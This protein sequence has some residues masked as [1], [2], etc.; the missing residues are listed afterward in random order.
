MPIIVEVIFA[1]LTF[2]LNAFLGLF[3]YLRNNKSWTNRFFLAL[4]LFLNGYVILNFISLH[5]P[6]T[7]PATQLFWIRLVMSEASFLGPTLF[8]LVHTFPKDKIQLHRNKIVPLLV[9]MIVSAI[10]SLSPFV[11]TSIEYPHGQPLPVPGPAIPIFFIDFA[12]LFFASFILLIY[13]HRK[14]KS[15]EKVQLFY[16]LLGI[17]GTF[18]LMTLTTVVSV[19]IF[20]FSG[21]VFL[22]PTYAL[23][24][25]G[26]IA[27]AIIRHRFLD[28]R[29]VV[30]RTVAYTIL[31]FLL[32]TM[33]AAGLF[34]IGTIITGVAT[35]ARELGVSTTLALVMA[36]T[37]QPLRKFLEKLTDKIFYKDR[38]DEQS[39][40]QKMSRIMAST[41]SLDEITSYLLNELL[42]QIKITRGAFVLFHDDKNLWLKP[43]ISA[44]I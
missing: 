14:A 37:F 35:P 16:F 34:I 22:G 38:Y 15:I 27:Y 10:L 36:F 11:F 41:I 25:I 32:G 40:L 31:I 43:S 20:K 13:K 23:I 26:F 7:S 28:I 1:F 3:V 30:A 18:T 8:L 4:T 6:D 42:S 33:Y 24:L 2:L 9:L 44:Q 39:F 29:L 17:I 12:G 19:V 21:L 5:P